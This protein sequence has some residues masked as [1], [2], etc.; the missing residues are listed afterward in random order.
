MITANGAWALG[1]EDRTGLIAS[2][3]PADFVILK[4]TGTPKTLV[5]A[6]AAIFESTTEVVSTFRGGQPIR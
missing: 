3:R 4:P 5:K 1:F 6:A 2:R